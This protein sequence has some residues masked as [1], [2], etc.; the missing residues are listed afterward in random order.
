LALIISTNSSDSLLK[1]GESTNISVSSTNYVLQTIDWQPQTA[2]SC[3]NCLS[4][5]AMPYST[6]TYK[7]KVK[8]TEGCEGTTEKEIKISKERP[9]FAPTAFSPNGDGNNDFFTLFGS[10]GAK[11]IKTLKIYNR[12]GSL[13]FSRES[14]SLNDQTLG[15][16]G[17]VNGQAVDSGVFVYYAEVAFVNGQIVQVQGDVTVM[18]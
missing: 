17:T 3:T 7:V 13:V 14:F 10:I 11:Q 6:T 2:L 4:T 12:W 8:T 5:I 9:V 18:K 1:L 15:W 16:D